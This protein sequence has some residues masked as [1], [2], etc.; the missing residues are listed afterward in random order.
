M[1]Q[2]LA[3]VVEGQDAAMGE[4]GFFWWVREEVGEKGVTGV[5]A[6]LL[7]P[8]HHWDPKE[9]KTPNKLLS[10]DKHLGL[11][12]LECP[13]HPLAPHRGQETCEHRK[14]H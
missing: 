10:Y 8:H 14:G 4:V 9:K 2:V 6:N 3:N 11:P 13:I 5:H 12:R 1:R 7:I